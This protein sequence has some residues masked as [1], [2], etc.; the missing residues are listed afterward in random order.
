[1]ADILS[2]DEIDRLLVAAG[3]EP[4]P[5]E[6]ELSTAQVQAVERLA[7]VFFAGANSALAALL[8]RPASVS[9]G[10]GQAVT[11]ADL[12]TTRHVLFVF[13]FRSGLSGEVVFLLRHRE[14]SQLADLILGG[15]GTAKDAL[16]EADLDALKEAMT[17]VA[18]SGAPNL[19]AALGR[20]VAFA[21]PEVREASRGQ[22]PSVLGWPQAFLSAGTAAVPGVLDTPFRFLVSPN[23]AR[24]MAHLARAGAGPSPGR[25]EPPPQPA[26]SEPAQ[27]RS[28]PA[29]APAAHQ[30]LHNIDLILDIE[31]EVMVRLGESVVP[32]K[33]I[34]RLR[35]GSII[36]LDKET[37]A[38]VELVVND[39]VIAKGEL[40]VVGS[41]HFALRITEV[42]TPT[43]RIRTLGP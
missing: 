19:S 31:V 40:V 38:P 15:E 3:T 4:A 39:R 10:L 1:M 13:P 30:D 25:E 35:P 8:A 17:Q 14:A 20:E 27:P 43:E 6:A 36:N 16:D 37:D 22:L 33:E 5:E 18:G 23:V 11:V 7:R 41:D 21:P 24:E 29:P 42:E 2:Q 28:G 32:L 12:D 9:E 34:Q 26:S